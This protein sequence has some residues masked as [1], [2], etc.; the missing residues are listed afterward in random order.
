MV[1]KG[2]TFAVPQ[3]CLD[4]GDGAEL[5]DREA[6][7]A[8]GW[9]LSSFS[10]EL[11]AFVV[12]E[13]RHVYEFDILDGKITEQFSSSEEGPLGLERI[14]DWDEKKLVIWLSRR[15]TALDLDFGDL[16]N[17]LRK[18]VDYQVQ[19]KK[20]L[21]ADLVRFRFVLAKILKEQIEINRK[22]AYKQG[23]Q[24]TLFEGEAARVTP[25]MSF[26]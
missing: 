24:E 6:C 26:S 13:S 17:Y 16:V 10:A 5:A 12:D 1:D 11:P 7:L 9:S 4:F 18:A 14:T 20:V 2:V 22:E 19:V 21:M 25:A 3:L 23:V 8:D 15:I